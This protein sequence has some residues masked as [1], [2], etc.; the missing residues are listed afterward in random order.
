RYPD[1]AL[2]ALING[3]DK[4]TEAYV[5]AGLIDIAAEAKGDRALAFLRRELKGPALISQLAAARGLMARGDD[6]GVQLMVDAWNKLA[7]TPAGGGG[8]PGL[9]TFLPN[10]PPPAA[11]KALGV[12]LRKRP[13]D[14]R[15]QVIETLNRS[16]G[17]EKNPLPPPLV[18]ARD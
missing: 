1:S 2:D 14:E 7:T 4:S 3:V 9:I 10:A 8:G 11:I 18:A 6:G 17:G 15:L 16:G 12:Q 13:I 5:R